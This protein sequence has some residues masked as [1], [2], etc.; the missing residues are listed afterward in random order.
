M[1]KILRILTKAHFSKEESKLYSRTDG[2]M[3]YGRLGIAYLTTLE[4]L[5]PNMKVRI[6]LIRAILNFYLMSKNADVSLRI[7]DCSLYTRRVKLNEDYHKKNWLNWH[8]LQLSITAWK[9]W[10]IHSGKHMEH[11]TYTSNSHRNDFNLCFTGFFAENPF[12]YQ[13]FNVRD[14]RILG[15]EQPIVHHDTTENCRLYVTTI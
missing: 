11:R 3:L 10:Q 9:H 14:I 1:K 7:V 8:M 12:C 13:Q 5:Y 4:L 2:F 6:R 15:G